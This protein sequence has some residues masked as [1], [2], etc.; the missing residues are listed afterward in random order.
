MTRIATESKVT[1][2]EVGGVE[3]VGLGNPTIVL[4]SHWNRREAVVIQP[5]GGG[6][7]YTVSAAD[8]MAAIRATGIQP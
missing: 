7:S 1:V 4:R 8:L 5:P 3:H 2:Y 6:P